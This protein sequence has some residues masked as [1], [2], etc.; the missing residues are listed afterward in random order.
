MFAA[1]GRLVYRH[2]RTVVVLAILVA[3]SMAFFA[4]RVGTAL[5]SGGWIDQASESSAVLT[6]D[7]D[8]FH[9]PRSSIVLVYFQ[10]GGD[11][12]SAAFQR[13]VAASVAGLRSDPR[14]DSVTGYAETHADRF[15]STDGTGAF[16]IVG[17][18]A[19]D[20]EA[21]DQ[22]DSLRAEIAPAPGLSMQMTGYAPLA[23]DSN[24]QSE[25]DLQRAETV[26]L[27][28]ALL[29]L[30]AVF[31][32]LVAA[33]MPLLVAALAIPTTLGVVDL[34][35][36][37]TEMSLYV[38]NTSTM[39]GLALAID[40][41]LFLVSRF[42]EELG[43]GRTTAEAVERAVATAGKAVVFSAVAVAI[44]LSGLTFFKASALTSIG[45]AGVIVVASSAIFA[46]TFLPAVLGMLGPRVNALSVAALLR[47]V[48]LRRQPVPDRAGASAS[49]RWER[50]ARWVMRHPVAV[51][52]PVLALLLALGVPFANIRQAVPDAAVFPPGVESR[53]AFAALQTRFPPGETTPVVVLADVTGD[54]TSPA[55]ALALARYAADLAAI[56]GV[57]RV[58]SPF[59]NLVAP[60]T[61][62]PMTPDQIALAWQDPAL[63]ARLQPLLDSYVR[64]SVVKLDAVSPFAPAQPQ[65]ADMIPIIRSLS[66][67]NG[68]TTRVGGHAAA[69]YDFLAAMAERIP[70]MVMTVIV[71]MLVVLFL[72][73]GSVVLPVK[74]V[75]MTLLSL[76]ASF[77]ALVWILQEGHLQDVLHFQSPGYTVAG[78]PI[79]MFAVIVGLSMDYEV[80]LLSRIQEVYRRTRDN[81]ASVAEGLARTAGVITGAAM[82][83]VVVFAAFS[84]ADTITIKS[85][86]VGMA[87]A[88]FLDATIIRVL[89]VPATM[90]LLGNLN[91]WAPGPLGRLAD[92]LGFSHVED[93]DSGD[94]GVAGEQ[95]PAVAGT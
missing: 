38:L 1:L 65:A 39:L 48:G 85:I 19:R 52:V 62:A 71:A 61:L 11:A 40:Y 8:L 14:V 88:V 82:I 30:I 6:A 45:V 28:L 3:S 58:D 18:T 91:W 43:R 79:I 49:G 75:L 67:G 26:S 36:E 77:G 4:A 13:S 89:L 87:I 25:K 9:A 22:I 32:S 53:D 94:E 21:V 33:G 78:V 24:A 17:L 10:P 55:N 93:D 72:L 69:G 50:V 57:T 84:L 74:A 95:A 31:A 64:G 66:A 47:R 12:R 54:P 20:E 27:P 73:F 76:S 60:Q 80:L 46:V 81:T 56:P 44:G 16:V 42:R 51:M 34:L 70:L 7:A 15:I 37:R 2:R 86:G 68:I 63:R 29:I 59:S 41:S 5:S 23:K 35:A 83:M 92:R 90:R